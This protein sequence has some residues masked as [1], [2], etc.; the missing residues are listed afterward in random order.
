MTKQRQSILPGVEQVRDEQTMKIIT[1][2]TSGLKRQFVKTTLEISL[3]NASPNEPPVPLYAYLVKLDDNRIKEYMPSKVWYDPSE[4]TGL[5]TLH[6]FN[7][8][9]Y[10]N[11][12]MP[13]TVRPFKENTYVMF[14]VPQKG[15]VIEYNCNIRLFMDQV[16]TE[17]GEM[18]F[19]IMFGEEEYGQI[20][21]NMDKKPTFTLRPDEEAI[22]KEYQEVSE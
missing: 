1:V 22:L 17:E 10:V 3:P 2:S 21:V 8:L 19:V 18:A 20:V 5:G 9:F 15:E 12:T 11:K 14:F 16:L 4:K 13:Q 6:N 7:I